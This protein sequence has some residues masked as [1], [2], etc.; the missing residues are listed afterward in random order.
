MEKA[1][2]ENDIKQLRL[3]L[4]SSSSSCP[5]QLF[6]ACCFAIKADAR[7]V[8]KFLYFYKGGTGFQLKQF[9]EWKTLNAF[10][11]PVALRYFQ[12]QFDGCG[13]KYIS[14]YGFNPSYF[15]GYSPTGLT[16]G[17]RPYDVRFTIHNLLENGN[18]MHEK[19]IENA[20]AG[21]VKSSFPLTLTDEIWRLVL[22]GPIIQIGSSPREYKPKENRLLAF[23]TKFSP[24]REWL[25][26][27]L[28][29][30]D[31]GLSLSMKNILREWL[32]ASGKLPCLLSNLK[33][34]PLSFTV[35]QRLSRKMLQNFRSGPFY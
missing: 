20:F 26:S 23:L 35:A 21:Q 8:L 14:I 1:V 29:N 24:R 17:Q 31:R 28:K 12:S 33:Q 25:V 7:L 13:S 30:S 6:E 2:Q 22:Y 16:S 11:Y 3:L 15:R 4:E 5:D 32:D 27:I 10:N 9:I 19:D 34:H 18:D